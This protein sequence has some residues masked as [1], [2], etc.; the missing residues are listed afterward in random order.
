LSRS[1]HGAASEGLWLLPVPETAGLCIPHPHPCS[2]PFAESRNQAIVF[3]LVHDLY[4]HPHAQLCKLMTSPMRENMQYFP[5][6]SL[7]QLIEK[8]PGTLSSLTSMYKEYTNEQNSV[9]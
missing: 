7:I 2:L 3:F 4:P 8:Y 1:E 5:E 9:T 6:S